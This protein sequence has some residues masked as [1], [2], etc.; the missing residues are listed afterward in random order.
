MTPRMN[1]DPPNGKDAVG[2]GDLY[3]IKIDFG[4]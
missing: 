2:A 1:I 3:S 4:N